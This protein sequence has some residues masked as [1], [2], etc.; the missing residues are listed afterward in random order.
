MRHRD[1]N[2]RAYKCYG[3]SVSGQSADAWFLI[4][5][6]KVV[7]LEQCS[8]LDNSKNSDLRHTWLDNRKN[9]VRETAWDNTRYSI[10]K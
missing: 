2:H 10:L 5:A 9:I 4:V 8:T 1:S 3:K 6:H 7:Y